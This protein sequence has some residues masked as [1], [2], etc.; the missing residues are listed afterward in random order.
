MV[1]LASIIVGV[2]GTDPSWRALAM[3]IG[4]ASRE[5]GR[6]HACFVYH[7]P[8]PAD[9]FVLAA[10]AVDL[11]PEEEGELGKTVREELELAG[12]SGDFTIRSGEIGHE[13]EALADACRGDLIVVGRSRHP[14][15]HLGGVPRQLLT[16][17]R[18][19][20][21]VVP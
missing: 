21:L 20:V 2:D 7:I 10:P 8:I 16:K 19:P 13:L 4:V 14:T 18:W 12:V 17:G 9:G 6:V 15:L 5:R 11:T 1:A 3:A